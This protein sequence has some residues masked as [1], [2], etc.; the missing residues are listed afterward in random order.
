M[1]LIG[2][3]AIVAQNLDGHRSLSIVAWVLLSIG[4][5]SILLMILVMAIALFAGRD[6]DMLRNEKTLVEGWLET[7]RGTKHAQRLKDM[8]PKIEWEQWGGMQVWLAL[9]SANRSSGV[10][11]R[12][13]TIFSRS[14]AFAII[15]AVL[16]ERWYVDWMLG[17]VGNNLGGVPHDTALGVVYFVTGNLYLLF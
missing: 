17:I 15:L 12:V 6:G 4:L 16:F 11:E 5:A 2:L 13:V 8:A 14:L 9:E 10:G 3:K 1:G 7:D